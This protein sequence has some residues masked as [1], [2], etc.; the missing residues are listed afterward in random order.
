MPAFTVIAGGTGSVLGNVAAGG[1]TWFQWTAPAA[2]DYVFTTRGPDTNFRT[3]LNLY[4]SD[5]TTIRP[6]LIAASFPN[7]L[8]YEFGSVVAFTV[9]A[10]GVYTIKVAGLNSTAA[11]Q[12]RLSWKPFNQLQLSDCDKCPPDWTAERCVGSVQI[13]DMNADAV[14]EFGSYPA[15]IY[16]VR[17][18]GGDVSTTG[19]WPV[20]VLSP[21]NYDVFA[22]GFTEWSWGIDYPANA[23]VF[24]DKGPTGSYPYW[25]Y[26]NGGYFLSNV[27]P[28]TR[29][30]PWDN[31]S[32]WDRLVDIESI[33]CGG[34]ALFCHP[35]GKVGIAWAGHILGGHDAVPP[36]QNPIYK[37]I[38]INPGVQPS[39]YSRNECVMWRSVFWPDFP[40]APD[41]D[42]FFQLFLYGYSNRAA[43]AW[44]LTA[45]VIS[46]SLTGGVVTQQ[47][48]T[49]GAYGI[50]SPGL[51]RVRFRL[52]YGADT[53]PAYPLVV[54]FVLTDS[55]S[56]DEVARYPGYVFT[57]AI[58]ARRAAGGWLCTISG[59]TFTGINLLIDNLGNA[60]E[61][62][63][64]VTAAGTGVYVK[65]KMNSG[66]GA[67]NPCPA[68]K[69]DA[70]N[71]TV[72][73]ALNSVGYMWVYVA[74]A[75]GFNSAT[76]KVTLSFTETG[77]SVIPPLVIMMPHPDHL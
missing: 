10:G 24:V 26:I 30:S 49:G 53:T 48:I 35:G 76:A 61:G 54:D 6:Y 8:G 38:N 60:P 59:T 43:L 52:A 44:N 47:E 37:L 42:F 67:Y 27:A 23:P 45:E 57:P 46:G 65:L 16:Y 32:E 18:C 66:D 71:D 15:G 64:T 13:A 74:V 7:G 3:S 73:G 9:A 25:N 17:S 28:T 11:G 34:S 58:A 68:S 41:Y 22:A 12:F 1:A 31:S 29:R 72:T 14:Y 51:N 33:E 39:Y 56:G 36:K 62:Y 75:P 4:A 21:A 5:F 77:G 2:G 69:P 70:F 50:L 40:G 19:G 55:C 63:V 20:A